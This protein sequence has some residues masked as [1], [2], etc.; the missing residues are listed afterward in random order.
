MFGEVFRSQESGSEAKCDLQ[1]VCLEIRWSGRR[2]ICWAA[3]RG[4][5]S[6][7]IFRSREILCAQMASNGGGSPPGLFQAAWAA[8]GAEE[9]C[10]W[11]RAIHRCLPM[12]AST[13]ATGRQPRL[14]RCDWR[15]T[16][17]PGTHDRFSSARS[18]PTL[19]L[20]PRADGAGSDESSAGPAI[21]SRQEDSWPPHSL[22]YATAHSLMILSPLLCSTPVPDLLS[23]FVILKKHT[24]RN[25]TV[26]ARSPSPTSHW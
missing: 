3:H 20:S 7:Y 2:G 6:R 11:A 22:Q 13:S 23:P 15:T 24:R 10:Y 9:Y 17:A 18:R 26:T 21:T 25:V 14:L 19:A 1:V 4:D 12:R 5:S 8:K 16:L